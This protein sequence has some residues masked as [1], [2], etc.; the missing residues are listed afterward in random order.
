M[1][2]GL[3]QN[4]G[5]YVSKVEAGSPAAESGL[6][7]GDV[8]LQIGDNAVFTTA[9]FSTYLQSFEAGSAVTVKVARPDREGEEVLSLDI[10]LGEAVL[11]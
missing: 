4:G 3:S 9:G 6:K 7:A 10:T 5:I 11:K 2:K 1:K 8:I